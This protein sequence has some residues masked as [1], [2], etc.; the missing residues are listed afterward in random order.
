MFEKKRKKRRRTMQRI[1]LTGFMGAG[2][3][4]IGQCLAK[5]LGLSMIDTDEYIEEQIGKTIKRI[6][7]EEGEAAFRQYE[8]EF[9]RAL[10][11]DKIIVTTGGGIVIQK[12]NRD[13]MKRTGTV[14]YLHC[15][16]AELLKRLE[17]DD[18]RP[19]L[20]QHHRQGLEELWQ[21]RLP[22]YQEADWIIDTTG[23]SIE[24]IVDEIMK[25]IKNDPPWKY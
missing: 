21:Q 25:M 14:I 3:T 11:L 2:K 16:F 10:P 5:R 17:H 12:E 15:E 20:S 4:T 1:Y 24:Q 9:L 13:W 23:Q 19:L 6:F 8:R 7:A 22:Y 18:T